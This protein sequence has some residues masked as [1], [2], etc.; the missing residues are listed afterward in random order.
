M[1]QDD[2]LNDK[3]Y[4]SS[5]PFTQVQA[6]PC[7]ISRSHVAK[8]DPFRSTVSPVLEL[9]TSDGGVKDENFGVRSRV[10][11]QQTN[12]HITVTLL[13]GGGVRHVMTRLK[14]GQ[15]PSDAIVQP[16]V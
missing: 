4:G 5:L 10:S 12:M 11:V 14:H 13:A 8:Q 3:S 6:D 7:S 2:K 9:R 1:R 16:H 15:Q